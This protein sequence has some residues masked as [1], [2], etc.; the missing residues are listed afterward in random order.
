MSAFSR[1]SC[2]VLIG[3]LGRSVVDIVGTLYPTYGDNWQPRQVGVCNRQHTLPDLAYL[4]GTTNQSPAD[5]ASPRG[6]PGA[7]EYSELTYASPSRTR[8]AADWGHS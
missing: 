7:P 5:T 8:N 6:V 4:V 1:H 2:T 3:N